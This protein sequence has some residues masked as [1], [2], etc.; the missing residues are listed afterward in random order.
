MTVR[1]GRPAL[2]TPEQSRQLRKL[3]ALHGAQGTQDILGCGVATLDALRSGVAQPKTV[4][5]IAAR[6][7]QLREGT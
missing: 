3:L 6:L 4:T 1:T 5:R 7:D 2:L